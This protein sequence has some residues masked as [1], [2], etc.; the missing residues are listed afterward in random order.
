MIAQGIMVSIPTYIYTYVST[1]T[2]HTDDTLRKQSPDV[3]IAH[4]LQRQLSQK[5]IH[6]FKD[7]LYVNIFTFSP[8]IDWDYRDLHIVHIW[9]ETGG[10]ANGEEN[11]FFY[12]S[13]LSQQ[14]NKFFHF[15]L[16][17]ST[18]GRMVSSSSFLSRRAP[19]V[20]NIIIKSTIYGIYIY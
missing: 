9:I 15:L 8:Y 16:F 20:V 4:L 7:L 5:R 18:M 2:L 11:A 10:M 14:V 19:N 6:G 13:I 12:V 3:L 17:D 1:D